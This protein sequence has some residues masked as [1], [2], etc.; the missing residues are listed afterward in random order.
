MHVFCKEKKTLFI[1][2][3]IVD[4]LT[5]RRSPGSQTC[6]CLDKD[7]RWWSRYRI[8]VAAWDLFE[9]SPE[10]ILMIYADMSR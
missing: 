8:N 5:H 4:C 7:L 1:D 3:Q 10:F 6:V 2:N 9:R